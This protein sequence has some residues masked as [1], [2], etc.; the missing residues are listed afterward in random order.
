VKKASGPYFPHWFAGEEEIVTHA[1]AIIG[2]IFIF[3][4]VFLFFD[5]IATRFE[6]KEWLLLLATVVAAL[7]AFAAAASS[8]RATIKRAKGREGKGS[9]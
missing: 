8:Y 7:V 3:V 1:T 9:S 6:G 2:A 5:F 4:V